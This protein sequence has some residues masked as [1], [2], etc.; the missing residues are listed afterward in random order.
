[1]APDGSRFRAAPW[2]SELLRAFLRRA[3]RPPADRA[4]LIQIVGLA[5]A[6]GRTRATRALALRFAAA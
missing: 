6:A 4:G 5:L 1:V 3:L 2:N